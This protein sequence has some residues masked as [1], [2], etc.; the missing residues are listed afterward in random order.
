[1]E[2]VREFW[3]GSLQDRARRFQGALPVSLPVARRCGSRGYRGALQEGSSEAEGSR[4]R[5][6][7]NLDSYADW[8]SAAAP[9][10]GRLPAGS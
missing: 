1:M 8:S 9:L 5:Y 10:G 2:I 4:H 7:E 3:G 6:P